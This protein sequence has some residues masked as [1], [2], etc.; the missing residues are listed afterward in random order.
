METWVGYLLLVGVPTLGLMFLWARKWDRGISTDTYGSFFLG[1]ERVGSEKTGNNNWGLCFAFANAIW[2]FAFLGYTYGPWAF[3]LQ[4][5]WTLSVFFIAALARKYIAASHAGTVHGFIQS[6]YGSRASIVAAVATLT[7][8]TLNCGFEIFYSAHLFAVA[9]NVTQIELVIAVGIAVFVGAYCTAGGYMASVRTDGYQNW[10]GVGGLLVLISALSIPYYNHSQ[11]ISV[12]SESTEYSTVPW[13]FIVGISVFAF[14]FNL[15][16]MANWQSLAANRKL[17]AESVREVQRGLRVSAMIQMF[18]P[19][20]LG[21]LLG[22]ML[23]GLQSGLKDE[24]YFRYA[25]GA[26]FP[27][28]GV[29]SGL[30]FGIV[31]LGFIAVT[32]SSADSYIVASL[33]TLVADVFKRKEVDEFFDEQTSVERRTEIE[34]GLIAGAKRVVIPLSI[35]MTLAFAI[36]YYTLTAFR[37]QGVAFQFQFVMYGAAVTLVPA[38][39]SRLLQI[40]PES[41]RPNRQIGAH[42]RVAMASI[43][44]GLCAVILPFIVAQIW[45]ES[46]PV[47]WTRGYFPSSLGPDT[48]INLT[49]AFGLFVASVVFFVGRG[50]R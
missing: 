4:I 38:V 13:H 17:N 11:S 10:L 45:W 15:V 39:M 28:M 47:A 16:D 6:N 14:F 12:F 19:A 9:F 20:F 2:Y 27:D 40:K 46:A 31:I 44:W 23:K 37:L 49:P 34:R 30:L 25:F 22:V 7:G 3:L 26:A 35:I 36:L 42:S 8:Y 41:E 32:I 5:P 21:T 24:S 50:H 18:A 43:G 29:V 48:I 33:Q 1:G